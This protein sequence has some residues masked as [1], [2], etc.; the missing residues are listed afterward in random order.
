MR[1]GHPDIVISGAYPPDN[2]IARFD[3]RLLSQALTNIVKNATEGIAATVKGRAPKID[4]TLRARRARRS[5][6]SGQ[7]QGISRRTA[8]GC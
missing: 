8:R 3:R 7:R 4:V 2:V 1:V 6:T 5:S